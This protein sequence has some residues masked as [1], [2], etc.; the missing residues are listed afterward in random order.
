MTINGKVA[1]VSG[2]FLDAPVPP[3]T[4]RTILSHA[5]NQFPPGWQAILRNTRQPP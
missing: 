3:Y 5:V 2:L 4:A 1:L